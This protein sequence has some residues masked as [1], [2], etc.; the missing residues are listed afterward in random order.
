MCVPKPA[1][2]GPGHAIPFLTSCRVRK[3]KLVLIS[4]LDAWMIENEDSLEKRK[5]SLSLQMKPNICS[6]GMRNEQTDQ[7]LTHLS[8]SASS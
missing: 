4:K 5:T 1:L 7:S 2:P 6:P 8:H 3:R